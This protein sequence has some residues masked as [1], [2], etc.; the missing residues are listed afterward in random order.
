MIRWSKPTY[1]RSSTRLPISA[2]K[3]SI[4][5]LVSQFSW[6]NMWSSTL[7]WRLAERNQTG[8][9]GSDEI[10][11]TVPAMLLGQ[12]NR[13]TPC[14]M[15]GA[16]TWWYFLDRTS[17]VLTGCF[18]DLEPCNLWSRFA[19]QN[20][21]PASANLPLRRGLSSKE[22]LEL[23]NSTKKSLCAILVIFVGWWFESVS[24]NCKINRKKLKQWTFGCF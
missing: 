4:F 7:Y 3:P 11:Q 18:R 24:F 17:A 21:K 20:G 6:Q 22:R 13:W 12:S 9:F 10:P 19:R 2:P 14:E 1:I 15:A 16:T 5:R 23:R 8:G